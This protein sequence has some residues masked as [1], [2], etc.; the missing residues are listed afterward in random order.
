MLLLRPNTCSRLHIIS[1]RLR[2]PT[3][4]TP[5]SINSITS[6]Y[7]C[8]RLALHNNRTLLGRYAKLSPTA[9]LLSVCRR[10]ASEV[11]KST[12]IVAPKAANKIPRRSDFGR[13]LQLAKPEKW[14]VGASVVCLIVSSVITMSVPYGIGKIMDIIFTDTFVAEKLSGFCMLMVGVFVVGAI[15]NFGRIYL[16]NGACK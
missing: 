1:A 3:T 16:M 12:N 4:T 9:S 7:Y 10:Y 11:A 13:L 6:Q 5:T 2:T 8:T 15:A 14:T